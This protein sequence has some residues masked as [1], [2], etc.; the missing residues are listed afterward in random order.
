[1]KRYI[2]GLLVAFGLIITLIVLLLTG[3]KKSG[4]EAHTKSLV[5]YAST[6]AQVSLL[7]DG[8]INADSLHNQVLITVDNTN[9]TYEHIKGYQGDAVSTKLFANNEPA[10]DA[11]LHALMR[12]GFSLGD[13]N[14]ALRDYQGWCPTGNRYIF[15]LSQ[16]GKTIQ[17][18]WNTS[19][20]HTKT[21]L[22]NTGLTI[23]L[24]QA[25]VPDYS[26]LT[27]D[28]PL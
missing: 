6:N 8:P 10:Y 22:G 25:Q 13:N 17:Q 5:D 3:G 23:Q 16:D 14:P 24:F 12:V 4:P 2:F 1:M 9:V 15:K 11:F 26:G 7:I 20:N 28:I 18:Y 19:C 21:Y 27:H